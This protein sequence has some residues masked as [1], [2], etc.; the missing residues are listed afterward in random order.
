M[1]RH[2][3][4][5]MV[6]SKGTVLGGM[7]GRKVPVLGTAGGEADGEGRAGGEIPGMTGGT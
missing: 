7:A 5:S 4:G 6:P 3:S 1:E 2:G